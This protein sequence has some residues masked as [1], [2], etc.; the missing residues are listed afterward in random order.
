MGT[1]KLYKFSSVFKLAVFQ[2]RNLGNLEPL[3][4]GVERGDYVRPFPAM[5]FRQT[6]PVGRS[7]L[8]NRFKEFVDLEEASPLDVDIDEGD[9]VVRPFPTTTLKSTKSIIP[10][11]KPAPQIRDLE[12]LRDF[13]DRIEEEEEPS[14][15]RVRSIFD[16]IKER[17]EEGEER[18]KPMLKEK[19]KLVE[20]KFPKPSETSIEKL[21]AAQ[22]RKLQ[23]KVKARGDDSPTPLERER[24]ERRKAQ[25]TVSEKDE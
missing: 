1:S 7:D 18:R 24:E 4:V 9:Y 16:K 3:D 17:T 10:T 21:R 12:K 25:E 8:K 13:V 23:E 20:Q 15:S 5:S 6:A 11:P 14:Q 2:E 22:L 19:K